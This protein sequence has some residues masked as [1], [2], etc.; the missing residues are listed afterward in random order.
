MTL[1]AYHFITT[2][3]AWEQCLH[4]LKQETRLAIDLEANSMFAY[5]EQVCLIQISTATHDY[6]IDPTEVLDLTGLDEIL[7]DQTVEKVFHAAEYDLILL[8]REYDWELNNLFDTMWAGRILGYK[9]YG[10]ASMLEALYEIK[11]DKRY[12]KSNW[13]KRP[14]DAAQL[15]YAQLDT[16]YLLQLRDD[17]GKQLEAANCCDEA[18]ETFRQQTRVKIAD[19]TF[20]P[21]SFWSIHGARDLTRRQQAVLKELHIYR[22]KAARSR[23]QP[24]FKIFGDRTLLETARR[25]PQ[26]E[27][28]LQTIYGMSPRQI[29]RHGRRLIRAVKTGKNASYPTYPKRGK[30]HPEDVMNR[31]EKL[32]NWRKKQAQKRGVESDVI[33]SRQALWA[34]AKANPQNVDELGNIEIIGEWRCRTYGDAILKLIG[35]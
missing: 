23:N 33:L 25:M 16:H 13:C 18:K 14:L 5:R 26:N 1:P 7:A 17:L 6:I 22:D 31:Y 24:L 2:A 28:Q 27:D 4:A 10:L 29:R 32:H 3:D 11:L 20:D 30:R 19:Q 15:K 34:I 9:R 12:Q 8:K 21:N 35:S